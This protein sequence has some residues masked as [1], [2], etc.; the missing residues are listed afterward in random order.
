LT[1]RMAE[2]AETAARRALARAQAALDAANARERALHEAF[3]RGEARSAEAGDAL[4]RAHEAVAAA[5]A[6][7]LRVG[8]DLRALRLGRKG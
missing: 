6:E 4:Q 8:S 2:D 1:A 7:L 3:H 5:K